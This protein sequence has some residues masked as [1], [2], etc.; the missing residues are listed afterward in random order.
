[1]TTN[2]TR[3]SQ[4]ITELYNTG[5]FKGLYFGK[6]VTKNPIKAYINSCLY[7]QRMTNSPELLDD[8]YN[9]CFVH[10]QSMKPDKFCAL[11]DEAPA[12][13]IAYAL[14]IISLK[15]FAEDPRYQN[16]KHSLIQS[17]RF[18][19]ASIGT[20]TGYICPCDVNETDLDL[21]TYNC[22]GTGG[23]GANAY[24]RPHTATSHDHDPDEFEQTYGFT[25]ESLISKLDDAERVTF[26]NMTGSKVRGKVS[27]ADKAKRS[28]LTNKL[29]TLKQQLTV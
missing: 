8:C 3:K 1:M 19:S 18:A 21:A 11:Y 7:K 14:R 9:E 4:L 16:P 24:N 13:V 28:L 17:L 6:A 10:L 27:N 29:L 25:L 22:M 23:L 12:K 20:S 2:E 5:C 26:Y 15:C